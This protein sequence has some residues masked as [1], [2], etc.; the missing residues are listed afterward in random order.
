MIG[1]PLKV[2]DLISDVKTGEIGIPEI[3]RDYVW[4][5]PQ[6]AKL[7]D[8]IYRGFPVGTLLLWDTALAVEMR[9]LKAGLAAPNKPDFRPKIVL[10][11]QQRLTSLARVFDPDLPRDE[12]VLFNVF[13][14]TFEPHSNRS[15][16]DPRWIDT[17]EL[18]S[19]SA[20][21]LDVLDRLV[22]A[23]VIDIAD[24]PAR[25]QI[26]DRLKRLHAIRQ[27]KFPIEIVKEDDLE[28]VTEIFIRVNSA[29][30]RLR[31][32][33]LAL[34]RLAWKLPGKVVGDF[35]KLEDACLERG[36]DIDTRFLMRALVVVGTGQSRFRDLKAYW[37]RPAAGLDRDWKRTERGLRSA[38]DFV[39][40][41]VGIPGSELL[42]SHMTLLPLVAVLGNRT[43]LSGAEGRA[44]RRWFLIANAFQ[45]YSGSTETILDQDLAT[46]GADSSGVEA[47]H[48]RALTDLRGKPEV[49]PDDLARAGA[50]SPLFF[51]SFLA[52]TSN[53]AVD[54]FTG[55]KIRRDNFNRDQDIEYHHIFPKKLLTAAGVD[56]YE[57]DEMANLAFLG[58]KANRRILAKEPAAYLAEIAEHDPGRLEAQCVPMDRRLWALDRF[59]DFLTARRALLSAEMNRLL[60][61]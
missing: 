7:L 40:G 12:R 4:R 39:E 17:T 20:S 35:E 25:N 61:S 37:Q 60:G 14:E 16:A 13:A 48:N 34:A 31:E 32:A 59:A 30:T 55:I 45:R 33:E 41:N 51:L 8:S 18:M 3:Q 53:D 27:Y 38:L 11:G 26:H 57:R 49:A 24:R 52:A 29:G 46:L 58:Q 42:P 28:V 9:G 56:R 44:L 1:H 5:K 19:G 2:E 15:A 22:E 54:W 50:S 23:G 6:I 43:H 21:E 10:D 36:F 47:L